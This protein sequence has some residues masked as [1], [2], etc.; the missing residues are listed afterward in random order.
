MAV[1]VRGLGVAVVGSDNAV[2]GCGL[3]GVGGAGVGGAGGAGG[4]G[5]ARAGGAGG[6]DG[7]GAGDAG[8]GRGRASPWPSIDTQQLPPP[9]GTIYLRLGPF[10]C[11][12]TTGR[13]GVAMG[14]GMATA[15]EVA[16][17]EVKEQQWGR[18]R[19]RRRARR[20]GH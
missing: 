7:A 13:V 16:A 4:V 12:A 10:V 17:V 14:A 1:L 3:G 11:I 5:G 15:G 6:A 8:G 20:R 9:G 2:E 19:A 18:R